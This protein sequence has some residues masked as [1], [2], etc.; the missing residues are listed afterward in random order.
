MTTPRDSVSK[1]GRVAH[2]LLPGEFPPWT[3]GALVWGGSA[4]LDFSISTLEK[5]PERVGPLIAPHAK[6]ASG[7]S[8]L[9]QQ[10][11]MRLGPGRFQWTAY[12]G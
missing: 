9:G 12:D 8:T 5:P 11:A 6:P 10:R 2:Q 1:A 4:S 7:L 3:P